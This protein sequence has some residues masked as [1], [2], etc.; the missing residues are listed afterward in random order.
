MR[1]PTAR[2]RSTRRSTNWFKQLGGQKDALE[3]KSTPEEWLGKYY[4][5]KG[6]LKNPQLKFW[7]DAAVQ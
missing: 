3:L 4:D 2:A 1:A 7:M 5:K 6:R